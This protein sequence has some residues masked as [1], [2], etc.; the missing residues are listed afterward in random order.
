M[1]KERPSFY[2]SSSFV[3]VALP[4]IAKSFDNVP[5]GNPPCCHADKT[6]GNTAKKKCLFAFSYWLLI[7]GLIW[8]FWLSLVTFKSL[9]LNVF[10]IVGF[11]QILF[12]SVFD[13]AEFNL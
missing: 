2:V 6:H 12:F 9:M 10:F 7:W 11:H 5:H 1:L 13:F 4:G 8:S 3:Y